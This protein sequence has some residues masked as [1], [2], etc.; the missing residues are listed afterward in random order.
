MKMSISIYCTF[1]DDKREAFIFALS[2]KIEELT[3]A[4]FDISRPVIVREITDTTIKTQLLM[5]SNKEEETNER[6]I[7]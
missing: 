1:P 5:L 4:G 6:E 3:R 7:Q 2:E